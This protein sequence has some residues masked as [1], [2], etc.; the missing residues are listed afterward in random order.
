VG[1]NL[2]GVVTR[3]VASRGYGFIQPE[4]DG[5]EILVHHSDIGELYELNEGQKVEFEVDETLPR[6]R[7]V[8]VTLVD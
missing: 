4:E 6:P 3:W 8:H 1:R 7:A 2:K 5:K